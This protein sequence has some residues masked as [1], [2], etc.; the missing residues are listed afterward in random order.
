MENFIYNI[1]TRAYFG[2]GQINNLAPGIKE[3]G[4]SKVLFVYGGRSIRKNGVYQAVIDELRKGGIEYVECSGIKPNPPVEDVNRG[5]EL[6]KKNN[7]NFILGV[8]GGSVI[9]AGKAMAAGVY[10]D[11]D[12]MELMVG[13]KGKIKNA[14]PL[15]SV[16]TMAGTGSEMDM[17]G[18]I[19]AGKDHKKYTIT[20]PLL[21]PKFSILDP[22]Y[23]FTVPEKHS[24]A[25][26]FDAFNHLMECYFISG[27]EST[28]VQNGMSE[29]VMKAIIKN[30]PLILKNPKDYNARANIM[31]ASS[32]ALAG[33]QFAIGKSQ[34]KWPMHRM[35][36]ELSSLCD[37]T[38]GVTLA[39]VAPAWMKFTLEKAPEYT[40]LFAAFA[41]NVFGVAEADDKIDAEKGI[42]K[43]IEFTLN[44]KMP[45][46]LKEAGVEENKLGYLTKNNR[47]RRY[48]SAL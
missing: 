30:A 4:G 7:L 32:Q 26:C 17:G 38:H 39:L 43:L 1:P 16:V 25:G 2:K 46:N 22:T 23:T 14:A 27:S 19:T 21:F 6:Y 8:G 47:I 11:G 3:F 40:W 41:R 34:S 45:K 18:V 31:W 28:D 24:M 9:D 5:I 15:A 36:H 13:G 29:G 10:Y 12:V 44:L 35:G 42:E 37:M 33:F 20:N 48:W